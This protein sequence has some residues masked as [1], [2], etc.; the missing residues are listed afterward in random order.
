[1]IAPRRRAHLGAHGR[2][3]RHATRGHCGQ[4]QPQRTCGPRRHASVWQEQHFLSANVGRTVVLLRNAAWRER[5]S[6]HLSLLQE[7][8]EREVRER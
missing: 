8:L 1:M 3:P 6:S 4:P 2:E 7:Q 5:A